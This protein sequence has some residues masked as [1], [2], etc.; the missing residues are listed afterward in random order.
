MLGYYGIFIY[1][2]FAL[3]ASINYTLD[4]SK[5]SDDKLF[6]V[7]ISNPLYHQIDR[8][9]LRTEG[10]IEHEG[11]FYTVVKQKLADD[12]LYVYFINNIEKEK[13][14]NELSIH[15]DVHVTDKATKSKKTENLLQGFI[16]EYL[17]FVI[18]NFI[19]KAY[20]IESLT[21][22]F[23]RFNILISNP[24]LSIHTPP[25]EFAWIYQ[26]V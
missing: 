6:L 11:K 26:D 7:K 13:L 20:K 18:S 15:N 4:Y 14:Y 8:P 2:E 9:E 12:T 17:P 22:L 10:E 16:K 19:L 23:T 24:A 3:K 1:R 5:I 25:P 21:A